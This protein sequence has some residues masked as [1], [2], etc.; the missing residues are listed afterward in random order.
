MV[1]YI[2]VVGSN[3]D[4]IRNS[5]RPAPDVAPGSRIALDNLTVEFDEALIQEYYTVDGD[6]STFQLGADYDFVTVNLDYTGT[7]QEFTLAEFLQNIEANCNFTPNGNKSLDYHA[8]RDGNYFVLKGVK[9]GL[10]LAN[11]NTEWNVTSGTPTVAAGSAVGNAADPAGSTIVSKLLAPRVQSAMRG[12][13]AAVGATKDFEFGLVDAND[14]TE[15]IIIGAAVKWNGTDSR[16]T[17]I[18]NGVDVDV[19]YNVSANHIA[20]MRYLGAGAWRIYLRRGNNIQA[21]SV[22]NG[23]PITKDVATQS[24]KWVIKFPTGSD[25]KFGAG[26]AA[27]AIQATF[28][29]SDSMLQSGEFL[30]TSIFTSSIN[31]PVSSLRKYLGFPDGTGTVRGDPAHLKGSAEMDG[32]TRLPG[33][34]VSLDSGVIDGYDGE[35]RNLSSIIAIVNQ[36]VKNKAGIVYESPFPKPVDLNLAYPRK[37]SDFV[38]TFINQ[39]NGDRLKFS[40]KAVVSLLLY[41]PDERV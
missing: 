38:I 11:V 7:E 25:A 18:E 13:I 41:G 37:M 14:A 24:L 21:A 16:W 36:F 26:V 29:S 34:I 8:Y 9:T 3:S 19:G 10:T 31:I 23:T 20:E 35:G 39:A 22:Y 6:N 27:N 17:A 2:R 5:M 40:G 28:T 15:T 1:K 4:E 12:Q 32:D 33:V 30:K